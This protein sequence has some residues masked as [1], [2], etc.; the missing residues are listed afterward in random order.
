MPDDAETR[1]SHVDEAVLDHAADSAGVDPDALAD[2][3]VV[4]DAELLSRHATLEREYD[5]ATVDDTRAYRVPASVWDD[6]VADFDF[7]DDLGA[8]V[9]LAHT[10]QARLV[11]ADAVRVDDGFADDERGVVVGVDTAEEF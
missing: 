10:E 7:G 3:L 6:L 9:E 4:L 8:A 5:Y 2:A 11:F 1:E